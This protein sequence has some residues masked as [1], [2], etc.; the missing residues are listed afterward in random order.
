MRG[1]PEKQAHKYICPRLIATSGHCKGKYCMAWRS[2]GIHPKLHRDED[3]GKWLENVGEGIEL[4]YCGLAGGL[5][6]K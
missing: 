6:L 3:T 2:A 5:E 1:I 4:G